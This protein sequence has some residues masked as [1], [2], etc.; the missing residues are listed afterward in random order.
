MVKEAL[1]EAT[2]FDIAEADPISAEADGA[3]ENNAAELDMGALRS[4]FDVFVDTSGEATLTVEVSSDGETWRPHDSI[5]YAGDTD[6]MEQFDT[7][8][9]HVRAY[10]DQ[11]HTT[12]EISAMVGF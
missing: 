1:P 12:V 5:D 9:Q 10:L 7:A 6:E 2:M 4:I 3:G 11:N 8:F